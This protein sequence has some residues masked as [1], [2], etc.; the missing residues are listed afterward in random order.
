MTPTTRT[1]M[2]ITFTT[3]L[4]NRK[5]VTIFGSRTTLTANQLRNI[6]NSFRNQNAFNS[7]IGQ[8]N[9]IYRAEVITDTT[10]QL[11]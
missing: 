5:K 3:N 11:I 7:E 9:G 2:A 4:G 6:E 8:V 10:T 1:Q